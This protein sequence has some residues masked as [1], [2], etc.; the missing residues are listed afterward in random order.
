MG[1]PLTTARFFAGKKIETEPAGRSEILGKM[2]KPDANVCRLHANSR[3][4]DLPDKGIGGGP[5]GPRAARQEGVNVV[6]LLLF[7]VCCLL[8]VLMDRPLASRSDD[9]RPGG[10][11]QRGNE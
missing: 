8:F 9:A 7:V 11:S 10:R 5:M 2:E 6:C 1:H 4:V 3:Q